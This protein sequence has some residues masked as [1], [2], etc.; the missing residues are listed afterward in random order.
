MDASLIYST[1]LMFSKLIRTFVLVFVGLA[2]TAFAQSAKPELL[3]YCG[4]TMV[5]PMTEIAQLFETRENIK[6]TIAQGGSEHLYQSAKKS[7]IGDW[8]LPGEPSFRAKYLKEGL[9]GNY[10]T[11]G[12]NQM[13]LMVQK[14]NPRQVKG[15]PHE[16]L[17]KDLTAIIGNATS[18]SVGQETKDILDSLKIYEKVVKATAGLSPDSRSLALVLKR[19]EADVVMNWRAVGFFSDNVGSMDTID[20]DPKLAKPQ[21][22]ELSLL[23]SSKQPE[24][25]KRFMNLAAGDEGQ[26]IFRK[27]G[28]LDNKTAVASK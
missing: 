2:G 14:G 9:L 15:N 1:T 6:L 26:A 8:Y 27:H 28:F 13:A 20:L 11:V 22:L 21:A 10:V 7:G 3:L 24:M 23:A 17:R 25:A 12:Y 16:L 4:I 18:G 19:K 5:R